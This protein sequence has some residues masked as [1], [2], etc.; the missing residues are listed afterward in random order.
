MS[1]CC[2]DSPDRAPPARL[3]HQP[4]SSHKAMAY[5]GAHFSYSATYPQFDPHLDHHLPAPSPTPP[6]CPA[7]PPGP[8]AQHDA[9]HPLSLLHPHSHSLPLPHDGDMDRDS[10]EA[11]D[12]KVADKRKVSAPSLATPVCATLVHSASTRRVDNEQG[13]GRPRDKVWD[14]YHGQHRALSRRRGK[15]QHLLM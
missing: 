13:G 4:A 6:P 1:D 10:S 3:A 5:A 7:P 12:D 15:V 11:D 2:C 14:F 8:G 9:A